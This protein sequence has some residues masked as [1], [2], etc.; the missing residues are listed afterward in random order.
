VAGPLLLTGSLANSIR[1]A[2]KTDEG[3]SRVGE[4]N[5]ARRI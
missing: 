5:L 3:G 2:P 4:N 1:F